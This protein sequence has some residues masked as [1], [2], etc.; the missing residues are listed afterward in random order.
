[1]DRAKP[2][3]SLLEGWVGHMGAEIQADAHRAIDGMRGDGRPV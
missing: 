2:R 3:T 1:M